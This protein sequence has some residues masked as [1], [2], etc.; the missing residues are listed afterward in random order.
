M[1]I[2]SCNNYSYSQQ[3]VYQEEINAVAGDITSIS[4]YYDSSTASGT[5]NSSD[6]TIYLGHTD[7]DRFATNNAW[8][9]LDDLTEVFGGTVTYP[10]IGNFMLISF[11]TPFPYN[12]VDNLVV[13]I[14]ENSIGSNCTLYFGK[15][16]NLGAPRSIYY[17]SDDTNPDPSAPP[18]AFGR[19][20]YINY[21]ILGGIQEACPAPSDLVV[22]ALSDVTASVGWTE[23]GTATEW[24]VLYGLAGFNPSTGGTI[25]IDNDGIP[26]TTISGLTSNTNYE[27]Y[28]TS[29]CG[30]DGNSMKI[31]PM[32]FRT[33]CGI[34]YVPYILDFEEVITPSLP[35]CTTNENLGQGNNWVTATYTDRGFNGKVLKYG[36]NSS[37]PANTWFYTQGIELE[38]GETYQ[39]S[40]KYGSAGL[41]YA[42]N[43]KVAFGTAPTSTA[44]TNELADYPNV[45]HE[46]LDIINTFTV[47]ANGIYYFGFNA[48]SA[49][50]QLNLYI[51][52]IEVFVAPTCIAPLDLAVNDVTADTASISW[53]EEATASEW[54]VLYGITGFDPENEG[55]TQTVTGAPEVT[56]TGLDS[57]AIYD[58]Y[59]TAICSAI[60]RSIRVGPESFRTICIPEGIPFVESF[61]SGYVDNEDLEGCWT[62]T[63]ISGA[64]NWVINENQAANNRAPRT[65]NFNV[66]LTYGNENWM[67]YPFELVA[68]STYELIFYARQDGNDG[69]N[70]NVQA[71]Y[72]T[73]NTPAAMINSI[74]ASS[75]VVGGDYQEFSGYFTPD[76][77][78]TYFVGIKGKMNSPHSPPW[79]LTMDDI[80]IQEATGCL[81]PSY[82]QVTS[83]SSDSVDVEWTENGS[84]TEWEVIYGVTGFNPATQGDTATATGTPEITLVDLIPN[85]G[86]DFYVKA[87]CGADESLLV[88][89]ISFVTSCVPEGIPFEEG[90]ESGYV[91][92]QDLAGCWTQNSITGA[93]KWRVNSTETS[94]NRSPRT[95]NFNI[96]LSYSNE[97]W[98]FYPLDLIEDTT[99]ELSFYARQNSETG[100]LIESAFGTMNASAAMTTNIIPSSAVV[101]GEYQKFT[102]YFTAASSRTYF[103][104]IKGTVGNSP[105]YVSVDDI[106]V[107]EAPACMWPSDLVVNEV[108]ENSAD[109]SWTPFFDNQIEWDIVYGAPGFNPETEGT[110]LHYE[111]IVP[112]TTIN[113]LE[114]ST[115]YEVY[116]RAVC[117]ADEVSLWTGP[118]SFFTQCVVLN[119]PYTMD[120]EGVFPPAISACTSGENLS[121]G[122]SWETAYVNQHGFTGK[123]LRYKWNSQHAA[124]TWFYIQGLNLNAGIEYQISYKYGNNSTALTERMRVA[125]GNS[126][127]SISMVNE[128]ADHTNV[129]GGVPNLETIVFTVPAD[130]VYYFGFN[131][132]SVADQF[133]LYIDDI[134][135]RHAADCDAVTNVEVTNFTENMATVSWAESVTAT[136]GYVV[137]VYLEGVNPYDADPVASETVAAG[138]TT[139]TVSGLIE[140][141]FYDVYVTSNCG[142][143][144]V[145][146]SEGVRFSTNV[147]S[148]NNNDYSQIKYFPNPV[149][150]NLTITADKSIDNVIV[151]NLLGQKVIQIQPRSMNVVIDFSSLP[152]GTYI[153]KANS[154][155]NLSTFKVLKK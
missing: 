155:D 56:L 91:H 112:E 14:D 80:S 148:L 31:G 144:N 79:Y 96:T 133:Y 117:S 69:A 121:N 123:T 1:P 39:I 43:L 88:G 30:A 53:S 100:V 110:L 101:D 37:Q 73:S 135:I 9:D 82:L 78:G 7:Q 128:L 141:V 92:G 132:L 15:T 116:V 94:S 27:F 129:T 111:G 34:A 72:G 138:I 130:G 24:E 45:T 58:F 105:M 8:V 107:T 90:F 113:N 147:L 142:D 149:K 124:N 36:Y 20:S 65:G 42:E 28:I 55:T 5:S 102:G 136:D 70:V 6:W 115:F 48:Y 150:E 146:M 145:I 114:T 108:T 67:Y 95:G 60:D 99:Y 98:I 140:D 22:N 19:A 89:P 97:D 10:A 143:G 16:P 106:S 29:L 26:G 17:R 32:A 77:S 35:V 54:E 49:A 139:T 18:V 52:D 85:T 3:I 86:Y 12:S 44:M 63:S 127:E 21:M 125:Y 122:N 13:A 59:V 83:I 71:A 47:P 64:R 76:T 104:G 119:L 25:L 2:N 137:D 68:G 66:T 4:F 120:F 50:N 81:R 153:L 46:A 38:T 87:V 40:Y 152:T 23:N 61:E 74:L 62:Q 134:H 75:E 131:A 11:D 109:L 151:Y 33:T 57:N 51:D 103:I 154:E 126:P 41:S 118:V 93:S 84:A